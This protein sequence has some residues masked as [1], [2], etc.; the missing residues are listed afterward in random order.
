[1]P[2]RAR[3]LGGRLVLDEPT[4]MPDGTEVDVA[5]Q[6]GD[7]LD[8]E[9]RAALHRALDESLEQEARG[10]VY[11]LGPVLGSIRAQR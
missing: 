6:R 11:D 1:M 3:G 9:E 8:A 5:T 4:S 2:F 7:D 10:E